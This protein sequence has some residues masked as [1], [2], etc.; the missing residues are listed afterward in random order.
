MAKHL[1]AFLK[2]KPAGKFS[3]INLPSILHVI[4]VVQTCLLTPPPVCLTAVPPPTLHITG[5][6]V[7][8]WK[9]SSNLWVSNDYLWPAVKS[10]KSLVS[11]SLK[12]APLSK[13]Q[14][15]VNFSLSNLVL[16]VRG[17]S[18]IKVK[19]VNK[20]R[21]VTVRRLIIF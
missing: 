11:L 18:K 3:C 2:S 5:S 19:N 7:R 21:T 8:N 1:F 16:F 10:P 9:T 14:K 17:A 15:Q 6:N 20:K 4:T 13:A 12:W